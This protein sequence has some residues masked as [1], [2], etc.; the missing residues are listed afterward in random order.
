MLAATVA[1]LAFS[2]TAAPAAVSRAAVRTESPLMAEQTSSRREL[3]ARAGAAVVGFSAAQAAQAK[4]GQ[5]SKID[6]FTL[7]MSGGT[8]ISSP[9]QVGGPKAGPEST[10]GYAKTAGEFVAKGYQSDVTREKAAFQV[11]CGI[12]TSQQK[13]IDSKTWWL[14][15][16]N[17]RGQAYT[18][19]ENMLAIN[20]QLSDPAAKKAA[21]AAYKSFWKEID[22][23]DLACK[24]K[25]LALAQKEY[26]DVLAA[27]KKYQE[28][29]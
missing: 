12:I 5:F 6:I 13:N 14:V 2:P 16:D 27:L 1:G 15:R 8:P 29:V 23:L 11:S 22:S 25:E 17:M 18:M 28:S 21:D 7:D 20:S 4:A 9:F 10:F 19:K 26:G 24:K 3:F